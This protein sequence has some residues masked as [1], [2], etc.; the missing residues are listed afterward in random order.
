M[1]RRR[2]FRTAT[3]ATL[4]RPRYPFVKGLVRTNTQDGLAGDSMGGRRDG[5]PRQRAF[6][7]GPT[8][9]P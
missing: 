1:T 5:W 6:G 2:K 3:H 7:A 4:V 8:S 9:W